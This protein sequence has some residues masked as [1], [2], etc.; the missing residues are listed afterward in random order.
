MMCFHVGGMN[1]STNNSLP[2][3]ACSY[4]R[5]WVRGKSRTS[6]RTV[7]IFVEFR[8]FVS[9]SQYRSILPWTT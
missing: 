7:P 6:P 5:C 4:I 3:S 8:G 9:C 2:V 1:N